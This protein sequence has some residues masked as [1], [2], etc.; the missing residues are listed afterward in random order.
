MPVGFVVLVLEKYKNPKIVI[1][2]MI[3]IFIKSFKFLFDI[4][5]YLGH[6][7]VTGVVSVSC[8]THC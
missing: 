8:V 4:K 2:I 5:Y 7:F 1:T 6:V 3:K